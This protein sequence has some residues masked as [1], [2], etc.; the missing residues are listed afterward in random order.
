MADCFQQPFRWEESGSKCG[1]AVTIQGGF[2]WDKVPP[3]KRKKP[4]PK[5]GAGV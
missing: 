4:T 2:R 3:V 1:L 5:I